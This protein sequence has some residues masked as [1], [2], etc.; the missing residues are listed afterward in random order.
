[1]NR[2][3]WWMIFLALISLPVIVQSQSN[4][5]SLEDAVEMFNENSLQQELAK[6]DELRKKGEAIQF[7]TYFNPEVSVFREQLNAG[8]LDYQETT[9]QISQPIEFLGQ[10]FLRKRSSEE[11]QKAAEFDYA[12]DR[13]LLLRRVKSLYSEAWYLK[14]KLAV[15]DD[16]LSIINNALESAKARQSEGTFSGIQV[17]RFSIEQNRYLK[18]RNEVELS[19]REV[20]NELETMILPKEAPVGS[21]SIQDSLGVI[22]LTLEKNLLTDAALESRADIK[23]LESRVNA[24]SFRLKVEKRERLPDLN[25]N[26]GYKNQSDG[27]EGYV[28]GASIKLP[29]FSQNSGQITTARASAQTLETSLYLK[30]KTIQN[31][32]DIAYNRVMNI[33]QQWET[34]QEQSFSQDMLET[35]QASYQEGR[36]SL[37]EL[38]DATQ[39]YADGQSLIY[40]TIADYNQALFQLEA[41][42]SD[43]LFTTQKSIEQ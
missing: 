31:Q 28:L 34:M 30:E 12:Y 33:Y 38:L 25:V 6:L 36:Y 15:Y 21:I 1:M 39:A 3:N 13:Q 35:A 18:S 2:I 23:A 41:M 42:T 4:P 26:F 43:Q 8:T 19:L 37:V 9:Y 27:S 5:I 16:A 22:P 24:S 11:S 40:E 14:N 17:Q 32:V 20:T 7:S 29:I 10:P